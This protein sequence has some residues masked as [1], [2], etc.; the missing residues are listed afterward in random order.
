MRIELNA[1][2]LG[3]GSTI[4]DFQSDM[5]DFIDSFDEMI[6]SFEGIKSR[7]YNLNCGVLRLRSALDCIERRI[8]DEEERK[9]NIVET[10]QKSNDFF[11]LASRIDREVA[12][13]VNQNKEEFYQTNPWLRPPQPQQPKS[14]LERGWDALC[15]FCGDVSEAVVDLFE[16]VG[17]AL[18]DF[19]K[20]IGSAVSDFMRDALS[21]AQ[22]A[23]DF[24]ADAF[25]KGVELVKDAVAK[26]IEWY[27]TSGA[28]EIIGMVLTTVGLVFDVVG[29]IAAIVV[30]VAATAGTLGIA[31]PLAISLAAI[32]VTSTVIDFADAFQAYPND[33]DAF[34][35]KREALEAEAAGDYDRA[36]Q[37]R[38][39]A[40]ALGEI[41][42][43]RD[44]WYND[45]DFN[46]L[47]ILGGTM[48]VVQFADFIG[49]FIELD[50][51]G[52]AKLPKALDVIN[53]IGGVYGKITKIIDYAQTGYNYAHDGIAWVINNRDDIANT[54]FTGLRNG[55]DALENVYN[56][57]SDCLD[58]IFPE[59]IPYIA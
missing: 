52:V 57:F 13:F 46:I 32:S 33:W 36:K 26:I 19:C 29:S 47:D 50:P 38:D 49:S 45:G 3:S 40:N 22:E 20:A 18:G 9:E 34:K 27:E 23:F 4:Y 54:T 7:T 8:G 25:C 24:V 6:E 53:T 51:T 21:L 59:P 16:S 2:G 12:E 37:L 31:A 15:D 10:Q 41:D 11:E 43:W 17:E 35:M 42:S 56:N 39:D 44:V 14:W 55:I 28:K 30:A 48:D 1:G 58:N 5:S